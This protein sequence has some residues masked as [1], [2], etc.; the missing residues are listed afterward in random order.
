MKAKP[1]EPKAGPSV[2]AVPQI[3]RITIDGQVFEMTRDEAQALAAMIDK[4]TGKPAAVDPIDRMK[5]LYDEEQK[6][7]RQHWPSPLPYDPGYPGPRDPHFY[8]R[9]M[10]EVKN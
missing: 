5:M 1:A 10:C 7:P 6:R 2:V 8:R 4:A 3:I 9:F